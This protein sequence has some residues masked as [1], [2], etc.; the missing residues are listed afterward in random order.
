MGKAETVDDIVMGRLQVRHVEGVA[1]REGHRAF[2]RD[3]HL[4][5]VQHGEMHRDRRG[6]GPT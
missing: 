1:Q 5:I 4:G 6:D 3:L 2:L